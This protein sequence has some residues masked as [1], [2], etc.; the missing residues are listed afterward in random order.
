MQKI[1]LVER[2]KMYMK[3]LGSGVHP[4]TGE[5]ISSDSALS[6]ER[7]KRC[8][9][10]ITTV[11]DEYIE[12]ATEEAEAQTKVERQPIVVPQ[13]LKFYITRE[14]SENIKLSKEP[15][16]TLTFMKNINSVIDSKTTEKLTSTRVNKWLCARG[17]ITAEKVPT[18]VHKTV[19]KPSELATR[20]GIVEEESVDKKSGEVK[21]QIKFGECAQ[22]FIIENLEDIISTT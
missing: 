14:Q 20:L 5:D 21:T 15:I 8:F 9:E 2:A 11:L 17:L 12:I 4:L 22:L 18:V 1:E 6:D 13:K 3:M 10:F 19:H 7:M 16:S